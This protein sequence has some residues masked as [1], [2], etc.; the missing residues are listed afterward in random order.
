LNYI[1]TGEVK[2]CVNKKW[3]LITKFAVGFS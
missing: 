1:K 2:N 3:L